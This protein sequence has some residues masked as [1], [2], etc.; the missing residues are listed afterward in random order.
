[1]PHYYCPRGQLVSADEALTPNKTLKDGYR[2]TLAP[3]ER[4]TFDLSF[5]DSAP[6]GS[7]VFMTDAKKGPASIDEAFLLAI[8]EKAKAASMKP[9]DWMAT[10]RPDDIEKIIATVATEFVARAG[11][12]GVASAF[13]FDAASKVSLEVAMARASHHRKFAFMGDRAPPFNEQSAT[14]QAQTKVND[15]AVAESREGIRRAHWIGR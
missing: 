7:S 15:A 10:Q 11:A 4:A 9:S 6:V 14:A 5:L 1:M 2:T 3:G 13:T 12:T 8:Q